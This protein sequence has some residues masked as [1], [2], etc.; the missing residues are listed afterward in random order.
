M[1]TKLIQ[2]RL[3]PS[4]LALIATIG[5]V[6]A[7]CSWVILVPAFN[8]TAW[9]VITLTTTCWLIKY[10]YFPHY[11]LDILVEEGKI[12]L[13]D[14]G[15]PQIAQLIKAQQLSFLV[16]LLSLALPSKQITIPVFIDSVKLTQYK[17]LRVF[18]LWY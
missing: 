6:A 14:E 16:T 7:A 10:L 2:L 18:L 11:Q 9:L 13:W 3:K 8:K 12:V 15:A 1:Q 17:A 5:V 4:K